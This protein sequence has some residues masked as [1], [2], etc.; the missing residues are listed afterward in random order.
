[1]IR[2]FTGHP[3]AANLLMLI[4]AALGVLAIPSL[5]RE[6]M[7]DVTPPEVEVRVIYPGA[8]AAEVEEAVC[9]RIEDALDSVRN[10]EEVRSEA[11]EGVA[12][13]V[14]EM[15]EGRDFAT[16]QDDIRSEI[17]AI[18]DFPAQV[19]DP[20]VTVLGREDLVFSVLVSGPMDATDLKDY[21]EYL[22]EEIQRVPEVS[23]VSIKGF[24]DRQLRVSL[25]A[26]KLRLHG[27]S[28]ADVRDRIA[29]QSVDVPA[30]TLETNQQDLLVRFVEQR[31]TSAELGSLI[32]VSE[33]S[34]AEVQLRELGTI[35]DE[36]ET[37]ESM[38]QVTGAGRAGML[39]IKKAKAEDA[40]RVAGAAEEI[41]ERER[42][43][44]PQLSFEITRNQT[45]GLRDQISLV[46]TNGWQGMVLVF[47]TMWLFFQI[48]LAWWVVAGL[49]ISIMGAMFFLPLLGITINFM[50]LVACL[51][52]LGLLMDD[53]IVIAENIARHRN[54]GKGALEAARLGI[55]EVKIGVFSSFL[56]TACILG[57]LA[58]L[59][60]QIGRTLEVVPIVLLLVLTVS[61][62]EAFFIL[63][64][65]LAH[66]LHHKVE[67]GWFR[68]RFDAGFA[69]VR[70]NVVGRGVD[71]LLRWRYLA[72][73][74]V[75]GIF[76]LSVAMLASGRLAFEGMPPIET[77]IMVAR[78]LMPQG[79]PLERTQEVVARVEKE[80]AEVEK[81]F[82]PRQPGGKLVQRAFVQFGENASAKE[83]GSHVATVY[84]DILTAEQRVGSIQDFL[85]SWRTRC[86]G[87][88]DVIQLVVTEPSTGP[89]GQA[90]EVRLSGEDLDRCKEA[91]G[92]VIAFYE[93]YVGVSNLLDDL[94][95]GKPERRLRLAEGGLRL[96]LDANRIAQQVSAAYRGA[97]AYE[98]QRGRESYEIDVRLASRDRSSLDDLDG[99]RII[100]PDGTA[101]PLDAVVD[102]DV[103]R[104]WARIA[105]FDGVRTVTVTGD[106]DTTVAKSAPI[107]AAMRRE[108]I[109]KLEEKYPELGVRLA[110]EAEESAQS[111]ASMVMSLFIGLFGVFILLSFQFRSYLEPIV[112]MTAIPFAFIG[113]IW[114]H[115]LVGLPFTM[116]SLLGFIALS[117]IVVNDSILLVEFLKE[118]RRA[119]VATLD[120]ASMATRMRFRAVL[121]TSATT[122]AGLL[123][124]LAERSL[125]AKIIQPI[126][127]STAFG[128]AAS[129]VL[130]LW[131]LPCFYSILDDFGWTEKIGAHDDDEF[132]DED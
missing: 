111:G 25:D 34:G 105:R 32:I 96:G 3:T 101:A 76:L 106:V 113:V 44:H 75:V 117:G 39:E 114:G 19:E 124:L 103:G 92:D 54:E 51:L 69:W 46:V 63:P 79:T 126:A 26:D 73:G 87:I 35:R 36:F 7:P 55:S 100:L 9:S 84:V 93:R 132:E 66:A 115:I 108:L 21:C 107:N 67:P 130:V 31:R 109:P 64:A 86:R 121:L 38:V 62:V 123:P 29:G 71:L 18:D 120:A 40:I 104:G 43:R 37:S 33:E 10:V 89:G 27:L 77:D 60:G 17:D 128:I 98:I 15:E 24:A 28:V 59:S 119:G 1:M 122:I 42:G 16:F 49:P 58:F 61:L 20:V 85:R 57:P 11:K 118:R 48:R 22:R 65:H 112:V 53:A 72:L 23:T 56:T 80:L 82:G 2:F 125:Q 116:P 50:S 129:T 74:S 78:I 131:I 81:E 52:A 4:L 13:V 41:I 12:V 90:I 91:A 5:T 30:G 94:R 6:S 47:F 14:A 83:S 110:G 102:I 70:E 45:T 68:R 127:V 97:T 88:P 99:L 95:P 8:S